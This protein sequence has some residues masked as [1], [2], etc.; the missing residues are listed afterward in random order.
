MYT[1]EREKAFRFNF[2]SHIA[3]TKSNRVEPTRDGR[4]RTNRTGRISKI[5]MRH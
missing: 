2:L 4:D 3:T 5:G 1:A